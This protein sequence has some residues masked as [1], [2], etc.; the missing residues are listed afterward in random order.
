MAKKHTARCTAP[1]GF[2]QRQGKNLKKHDMKIDLTARI[3]LVTGSTA[4][5][6]KARCETS[7]FFITLADA[8]L[9]AVYDNRLP[10][11]ECSIVACQ[12]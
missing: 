12:K 4:G 5:V 11:D 6:G 9:T 3:A 7:P 10:G 2:H 8:I 1:R